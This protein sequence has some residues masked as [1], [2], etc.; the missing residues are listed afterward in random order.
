M[1]E[2]LDEHL[3]PTLSNLV[4][5]HVPVF[6]LINYNPIPVEIIK[7]RITFPEDMM[8]LNPKEYVLSPELLESITAYIIIHGVPEA[9]KR[10]V[11]DVFGYPDYLAA[12]ILSNI[13]PEMEPIY[14]R[15]LCIEI[16]PEYQMSLSVLAEY[17]LNHDVEDA[18]DTLLLA[19]GYAG[20][21]DIAREVIER[22]PDMQC[23]ESVEELLHICPELVAYYIVVSRDY[24]AVDWFFSV[25]TYEL[26]LSTTE[27]RQIRDDLLNHALTA[28]T[29][30]LATLTL[31]YLYTQP[32]DIFNY[33]RRRLDAGA[34]PSK[35]EL[36]ANHPMALTGTRSRDW[37]S[38]AMKA[39]SLGDDEAKRLL[40]SLSERV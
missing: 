35:L 36:I 26:L 16:P 12:L 11:I 27:I 3:I 2:A 33:I 25:G 10:S 14:I 34:I 13:L 22:N 29:D 5:Q 15:Q 37:V 8:T 21:S 31:D 1:E 30:L 23:T 20:K 4:L 17:I 24:F 40:L 18:Y 39:K 6:D 38:L 19:A 7:R 28:D 9:I 32:R